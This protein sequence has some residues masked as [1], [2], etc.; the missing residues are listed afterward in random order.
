M[1]DDSLKRVEKLLLQLV[2]RLEKLEELL[3]K[4]YDDPALIT[5]LELTLNFSTPIY[6][7]V[8]LARNIIETLKIAKTQ[9]PITKAIL[10]ALVI[11]KNGI[12]I[13]ELTRK[14]R[15]LRGVASRRI[16]TERLKTLEQK[17]I[18]ELKKKRNIT[19]IYLK[20]EHQ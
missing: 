16:I 11:S 19:R 2:D 18:V 9:D 1:S 14:V 8:N 12:S 4:I 5:A 13:S 20:R 3:L 7:A 17:G 15:E 6:K 10:E